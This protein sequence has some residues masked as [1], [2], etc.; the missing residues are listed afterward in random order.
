MAVSGGSELLENLCIR[1]TK[2][3]KQL[4]ER[5]CRRA[6]KIGKV[7]HLKEAGFDEALGSGD[8]GE[9]L[10]L[11]WMPSGCYLR[12]LAIDKGSGLKAYFRSLTGFSKRLAQV[13]G[14]WLRNS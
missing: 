12:R 14:D 11:G 10:L 5:I 3:D 7:W 1:I 2:R 8:R 4:L 13:L 6:V 9:A